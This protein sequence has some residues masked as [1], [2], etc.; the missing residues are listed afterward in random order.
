MTWAARFNSVRDEDLIAN[1]LTIIERDYKPALDVLYP[2]L[3][4]SDFKQTAIGQIIRLEFPC[5]S[6]SPRSNASSPSEDGGYL[7]QAFRVGFQV[8][9]TDDSDAHVTNR[10]MW[11]MTTMGEVLRSATKAD[12]FA[13]MAAQTFEYV[14]ESEWEYGPSGQNESILFR[15]ADMTATITVNAR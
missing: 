1:M 12:M 6:A 15:A 10:I 11:Y 8:G 14:F 9:V 5:L 3:D 7:R 4:L 13:G 2:T